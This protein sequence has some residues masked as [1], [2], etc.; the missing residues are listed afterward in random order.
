MDGKFSIGYRD[1]VVRTVVSLDRETTAAYTLILEAIGMH[2]PYL[3]TTNGVVLGGVHV[4]CPSG[5]NQALSQRLCLDVSG[6]KATK[7]PVYF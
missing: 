7:H 5:A 6:E 1:A 2:G 4:G 3:H